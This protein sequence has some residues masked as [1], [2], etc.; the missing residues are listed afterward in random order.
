MKFFTAL[1]AVRFSS[2]VWADTALADDRPITTV[3]KLLQEMLDSSTADGDSERTL[4]GKYKCY[5]DTNEAEK[6]ESIESLTQAVTTLENEIDELQS[7]NGELSR[8]SDKLVKDM[9]ANKQSRADALALRNEEKDAYEAM[10]NDSTTAIEQMEEAI[11]E[12]ASVGADQTAASAA[13]H[14][15]YMAAQQSLL[16]V[17]SSVRRVMLAAKSSANSK[18]AA[19][20]ASFLA[21]PFTATY[22]SQA[23]EV[24]GILKN[25]VDTFTSNLES[26]RVE[27]EQAE[28]AFKAF[29]E[30]KEDE[31]NTMSKSNTD[32]QEQLSSNDSEMS[33]KENQLN[34][35]KSTKSSDEA[36]LA[37]LMDMCA[38]KANQYKQRTSLR[39]NEEA[40]LSEAISILNSDAAFQAFGKVDATK[41][42]AVSL[43][44]FRS[45]HLHAGDLASDTTSQQARTLLRKAGKKTGSLALTKIAALLEAHNP[46]TVVLEEINKMI[47]LI[48]KEQEADKNKKDWCEEERR[49][50]N[51]E[52][53][54]RNGEIEELK[55]RITSLHD[56]IHHETTGLLAQISTT[57]ATIVSNRNSQE[58]QTISRKEANVEYQKDIAHLV[59]AEKL[60]HRAVAVL[61]AYYS[62]IVPAD[63]ASF[64]QS[65]PEPPSTWDDK[66][67]GQSSKGGSAI[68]ML[69]F[70]LK[71]TKDEEAEAHKTEA[72]DQ[73]EYETSMASLK[74]EEKQLMSA[75]SSLNE[76]LAV[77]KKQLLETED[78]HKTTIA[79]KEA[80]EDYLAKI[81]PGC[82]F[83]SNNFDTRSSN[84]DAEKQALEDASKLLKETPVYTAAVA[85][86]HNE[87]LGDCL[88]SCAGAEE[89]VV[90]KACRAKVTIPGY[91]AGHPETQGCGD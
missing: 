10:S 49:T 11:K 58:T 19:A 50:N 43:F 27:E 64:V 33:T 24:V 29:T 6:K 36:F 73:D 31:F 30:V 37:S 45:I 23:G 78:E 5:C 39:R 8:L 81:K 9:A 40:A 21:E 87:T 85:A 59:E 89:T 20:V 71:N 28:K 80:I 70:I 61:E 14:K 22:S 88:S 38:A 52:L 16:S 83:I 7:R 53:N 12:L 56:E 3:V 60:L 25:M 35:A 82:D 62:K 54:N 32:A 86:Q 63:E 76:N 72:Q 69:T 68:E 55:S 13:D 65:E 79:Q 77:A 15:T 84:R 2:L 44:Q 47:S 66:Y 42:G 90:C 26:A 57:E 75:L 18:Q 34:V 51:Q 48:G 1:T 46:F 17:R 41:T 91:C 4:Y 67:V 74:A